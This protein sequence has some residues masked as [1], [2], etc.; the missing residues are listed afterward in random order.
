MKRIGETTWNKNKPMHSLYGEQTDW[1]QTLMTKINQCGAQLF[2]ERIKNENTQEVKRRIIV[3]TS[4]KDVFET[5]MFYDSEKQLHTGRFPVEFNDI[6]ENNE[7]HVVENNNYAVI[8][9]VE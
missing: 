8:R 5:L 4:F 6:I 9:L 2:Q 3:P 7:I 1:N